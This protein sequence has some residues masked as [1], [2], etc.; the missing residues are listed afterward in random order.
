MNSGP[1]RIGELALRIN[2][3]RRFFFNS[4]PR[5]KVNMSKY[6]HTLALWGWEAV[7]GCFW[8]S[9]WCP[10][11]T[12]LQTNSHTILATD[13]A[14]CPSADVTHVLRFQHLL[15]NPFS[16]S[17]CSWSSKNLFPLCSTGFSYAFTFLKYFIQ[18]SWKFCVGKISLN[19]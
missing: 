8:P 5:A 7:L 18:H 19:F 10:F 17:P 12:S 14:S 9:F 6:L 2:P 1:R 3:Q 15:N 16:P 4:L 11:F 13:F